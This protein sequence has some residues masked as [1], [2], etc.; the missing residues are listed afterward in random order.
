MG[1]GGVVS[2][3]PKAGY[4][5][6]DVLEYEVCDTSVPEA[7]CSR[8][9]VS[10]VV[11]AR[12][13]TAVDDSAQTAYLTAVTVAVLSNDLAGAQPLQASSV[14]ILQQA[15]NG[16]AVVEADGRI[17]YTPA[18]G[19]TGS[20]T[21]RYEVCDNSTPTALCSSALLTVVVQG[22]PAEVIVLRYRLVTIDYDVLGQVMRATV[23]TRRQ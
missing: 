17:R 23:Q 21:I 10:I 16:V 6:S 8:A 1:A 5:G 12:G 2:Y 20:D 4:H 18:S 11:V 19:F 15:S 3:V 22:I 7:L 14:S 13:P 9:N